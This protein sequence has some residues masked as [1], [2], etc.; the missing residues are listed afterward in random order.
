VDEN[1]V[2]YREAMDRIR[3]ADVVLTTYQASPC[4][5]DLAHAT[6]AQCCYHAQHGFTK[7]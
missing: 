1:Q 5:L 3:Q 4:C 6:H 7:S 2:Q